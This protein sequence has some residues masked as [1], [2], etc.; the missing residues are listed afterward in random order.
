MSHPRKSRRQ[1]T[2][3]IIV[4]V[5]LGLATMIVLGAVK[6]SIRQRRQMRLELQ[7][8]QTKWMLDAGIRKAVVHWQTHPVEDG[9]S[10]TLIPGLEKYPNATVMITVIQTNPTPGEI[11]LNVT[12]RIGDSDDGVETTQRSKEIVIAKPKDPE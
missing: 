6:T 5:C 7:M 4:L 1:G 9:E 10:L 2:I 12:A 3:L 8:V 11:H